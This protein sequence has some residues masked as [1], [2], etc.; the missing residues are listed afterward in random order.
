MGQPLSFFNFSLKKL[1]LTEPDS[2]IRAKIKILFTILVLTLLKLLINIIVSWNFNQYFQL[3]RALLMLMVS[4]TLLKMLLADK[5]TVAAI[6]HILILSSLILVWSNVFVTV[7]GL[8][9]I[10][11]QFVF[12]IILSSFYL[13]PRYFGVLYAFLSSLPII[14]YV[15]QGQHLLQG[16]VS[17]AELA[18]PGYEIIVVLNFITIIISHYLYHQAFNVN[19]SEK[20][21]LNHQLQIAVEEATLAAQSKSDFLSTMSHELRTPLNAVIGMSELL[22]DNP[23]NDEE[24]ENLK[25]LRFSAVTLH[26][27]VND[28]LDFNKLDSDKLR[29]EAISVD[30]YELI[31]NI[32]SGLRF[33]AKEK[34]LS[35]ITDI[36]QAIKEQHIITDPTRISQI[37][38]NLAG[39]AIKFTSKGSVTVSLKTISSD[40]DNIGIRFAVTDTGIGISA[41]KHDKIFEL[42]V[43]ASTSTTRNYGGTGLG[44]TIVKRLLKLFRSDIHLISSPN[45]G[46]TFYF[47][48]VLKLDKQPAAVHA[49]NAILK[50]DLSGLKVLIAEDNS[51]NRLLL[52][53]VFSKW[54][55][56]PVF[57]E[58]GQ[59]AIEKI[60]SQVYDVVLMD[61]H[62]PVI[63][64]Y[65]AAKA[66]RKIKDPAIS[67][68]P[69]IALTASVSNNLHKKI[70]AAGMNDYIYKPFNTEN[71]YGKLKDIPVRVQSI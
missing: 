11:L 1:L 49:E 20:E 24:A 5:K 33:Q 38:Y 9:I 2:F 36:D 19:I 15:L 12:M 58:N 6:T 70:K 61:I 65:E 43:Q 14:I 66:I 63:D 69:I 59:E 10:T 56:D 23:R 25:I 48:V 62:M 53:K 37:I 42:F 8:N 47:D 52:K 32:C 50:Y 51:I 64:G 45:K 22:L 54:N 67:G 40:K 27:L 17:D 68:V 34:G 18:S 7:K 4:V 28:I 71:L 35:L 13:L 31:N 3:G 44:L 46:S 26:T 41:D 39:N 16:R 55:N 60:S 57:A 21:A 30:L 29:L